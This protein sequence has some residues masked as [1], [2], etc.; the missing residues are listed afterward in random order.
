MLNCQ[1]GFPKETDRWLWRNWW[2]HWAVYLISFDRTTSLFEAVFL[3]FRLRIVLK[4]TVHITIQFYTI[5]RVFA[6]ELSLPVGK[7]RGKR[8]RVDQVF[9][10]G[11]S[12]DPYPS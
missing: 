12:R 7:W 2:K 4:E 9:A 10:R 1:Y 6:V 8:S 3:I 5:D 11:G